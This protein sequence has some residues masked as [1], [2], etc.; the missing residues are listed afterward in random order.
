MIV[1]MLC[2]QISAVDLSP[3]SMLLSYVAFP[4]QKQET[5]VSQP[6]SV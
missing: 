3:F 2:H 1:M 4:I 6:M 5:A